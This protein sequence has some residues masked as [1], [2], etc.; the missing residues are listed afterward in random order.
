MSLS[1]SYL[2]PLS[3]L[4]GREPCGDRILRSCLQN[5]SATAHSNCRYVMLKM[6]R[7]QSTTFFGDHPFSIKHPQDNISLQNVNWHPPKCKLTPSKKGLA[8]ANLQALCR[9]TQKSLLANLHSGGREF[10]FWRLKLSWGCCMEK[11]GPPKR[12][13]LWLLPKKQTEGS[14]KN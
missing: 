4:L 11:G 1:R 2:S 12:V 7:S 6:G 14:G 13:V 9:N 10:A 8:T 3:L 5:A